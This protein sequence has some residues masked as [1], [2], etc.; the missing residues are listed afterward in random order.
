MSP[1]T[2]AAMAQGYRFVGEV[3]GGVLGGVGLGWLLDHYAKVTAPWGV[4]GGLLIGTGFSIFT[5]VTAVGRA[6]KIALGASG[7]VPGA[8]DDKDED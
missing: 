4:V 1:E 7:T 3:V 6:N 5:A 8:T 2:H